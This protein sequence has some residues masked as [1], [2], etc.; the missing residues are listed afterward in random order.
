MDIIPA[1]TVVSWRACS[2]TNCVTFDQDG[3][4][5][6]TGKVSPLSF[7]CFLSVFQLQYIYCTVM[8]S[9]QWNLTIK[10]THGIEQNRP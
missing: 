1:V 5:R 6:E 8:Y 2:T 7:M 4:Q 3:H 10:V 9:V